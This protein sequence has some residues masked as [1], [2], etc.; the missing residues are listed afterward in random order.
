MNLVS[1]TIQKFVYKEKLVG[2]SAFNPRYFKVCFS[3]IVQR[4]AVIGESC[5]VCTA[6]SMY[7]SFMLMYV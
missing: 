4:V 7:V 6:M 1:L 5:S 3:C 2:Y